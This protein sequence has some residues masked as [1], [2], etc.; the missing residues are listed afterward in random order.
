[1]SM[2]K[3]SLQRAPWCCVSRRC[4][5]LVK[6]HGAGVLVACAAGLICMLGQEWT[7]EAEGG[8]HMLRHLEAR[9]ATDVCV[10]AG[11]ATRAAVAAMTGCAKHVY[12][13]RPARRLNMRKCELS[14]TIGQSSLTWT[15]QM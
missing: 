3:G 9:I 11:V 1:M 8:A 5:L 2:P 13:A 7:T 4:G 10:K 14:A 12:P 15:L 6:Q